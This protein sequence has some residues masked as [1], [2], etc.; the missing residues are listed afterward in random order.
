MCRHKGPVIN[1][2]QKKRRKIKQNKKLVLVVQLIRSFQAKAEKKNMTKLHKICIASERIFTVRA[3][4][5]CI[6]ITPQEVPDNVTVGI[7]TFHLRK[8]KK[9]KKNTGTRTLS[10]RGMGDKKENRTR[11]SSWTNTD[12][13]SAKEGVKGC[14]KLSHFHR[15]STL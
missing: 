15:A 7:K 12:W 3:C 5:T 8:P 10:S 6:H 1:L 13:D 9:K 14:S 11:S 4:C 2:G